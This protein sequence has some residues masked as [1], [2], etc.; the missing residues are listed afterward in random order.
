MRFSF[1]MHVGLRIGARQ[2]LILSTV[3]APWRR[4]LHRCSADTSAPT[5]DVAYKPY[6][7]WAKNCGKSCFIL[8]SPLCRVSRSEDIPVMLYSLDDITR[9]LDSPSSLVVLFDW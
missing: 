6:L 4:Y 2:V 8:A 9:L 5:F 7:L 1:D 3:F